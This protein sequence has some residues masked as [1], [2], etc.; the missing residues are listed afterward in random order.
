MIHPTYSLMWPLFPFIDV[1]EPNPFMSLG[2]WWSW[3]G[4]PT[5]IATITRWDL[6]WSHHQEGGPKMITLLFYPFI[7]KI[8][9]NTLLILGLFWWFAVKG[10]NLAG[11]TRLDEILK[12]QILKWCNISNLR[13]QELQSRPSS[14][15]FSNYVGPDLHIL[16]VRLG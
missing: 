1:S 10:H 8:F 15:S 6:S 7:G 13:F 11:S 3:W 4:G 9:P 14:K 16:K 12:F 2:T 5:I